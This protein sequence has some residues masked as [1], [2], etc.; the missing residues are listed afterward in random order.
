VLLSVSLLVPA[1]AEPPAQLNIPFAAEFR[2]VAVECD[3]GN[4]V[5]L[6]DLRFYVFD[7]HLRDSAGKMQQLRLSNDDSWQ[8]DGVAL[9]DLE[10]GQ[11]N[12]LNGTAAINDVLRGSIAAADYR[13]LTFTLG[14]PFE[15]NHSD[16]LR[17]AAPLD[18]PAMHWH[19]RGG[20]KFLRA[21]LGTATDGFWLHLGSTGCEG[22]LQNITG[23]HA[24]NRVTVEL[25]NFVPGRDIVVV[26]LGELLTDAELADGTA[27]DCSS[28]P[29][30]RHCETA[31]R[32]LGLDHAGGAGRDEQRL[33]SSRNRQ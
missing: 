28:G 16:P 3:A 21:G 11:Y 18:D 4:D 13:G 20:Y 1:C 27:S 23:C 8:R 5:T 32:A 33:F 25:E 9:L 31:F 6:S 14:V 24:P 10:D 17:A 2:G 7:V 15:R 30:E 26:D 29:A 19:W 12:C 22:T